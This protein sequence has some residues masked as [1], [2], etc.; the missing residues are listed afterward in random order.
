MRI[1]NSMLIKDMLWNANRNLTGMAKSQNE[2]S[3]GKRIQRP[4]DDPVGITQV[5]KYKADIRETEQYAENISDSLGW[6]EVTESALDDVKEILQRVREL[7]V[8][9]SNGTY[10]P[11]DTTKIKTEI[12]QLTKE[13]IVLGNSTIAGRYIFSGLETDQALFDEDGNYNINISSERNKLKDVLNFEVSVGET[14]EVSTHPIDVFGVISMNNFFEELFAERSAETTEATKAK[15]ELSID[16]NHDYSSSVLDIKLK[17]TAYGDLQY[18]VDE[19]LLTNNISDPLTKSRIIE[20]LKLATIVNS[21]NVNYSGDTTDSAAILAGGTN[22]VSVSPTSDLTTGAY[23]IVVNKYSQES[24]LPIDIDGLF[25][26]NSINATEGDYLIKTAASLT[27]ANGVGS[28]LNVISNIEI[29]PSSTLND[30]AEDFT[31]QINQLDADETDGSIAYQLNLVGSVSGVLE[32]AMTT[33]TSNSGATNIQLGD[34]TFS[35]DPS[36]LWAD[37]TSAGSGA[38]TYGS[39][40]GNTVQLTVSNLVTA[41]QVSTGE[42]AMATNSGVLADGTDGTI[43]FNFTDGGSAS[44]DVVDS[45]GGIVR[46]NSYLTTVS[47]LDMY[48]VSL[49]SDGASAPANGLGDFTFSEADIAATPGIVN[50]IPIGTLANGISID[51]NASAL[52]A[53]S[54]GTHVISVDVADVANVAADNGISTLGKMA[55]IYFDQNDKLVIE[56]KE[57]GDGVS[58]GTKSFLKTNVDLTHDYTAGDVLDLNINGTTFQVDESTL[59]GSVTA[60]T[61]NDIVNAYKTATDGTNLLGDIADIYY[62]PEGKLVI[63]PKNF[64]SNFSIDSS[65]IVSTGIQ[66]ISVGNE[67]SYTLGTD[68]GDSIVSTSSHLTD[69]M[70][71]DAKDVSVLILKVDGEPQNIE[72]D[73]SKLSSVNDLIS[74]IQNQVDDKFGANKVVI[75]GGDG[76]ALDFK[77]LG[78]D[79]GEKHT[80]EVDYQFT[81]ESELVHD[82]KALSAAFE[83]KDDAVI[84]ASLTKLD[85]HLDRVLTA[86]GEVGGKTNRV[87]FISNRVSD[88]KLTFTSLM[89]NVQ[90]VDMAESIMLFKNLEN[91]YRASLSV[92]AKVIQ[93]SLVDF[94]Q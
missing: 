61:Q 39:Y 16:L 2:L 67:P 84:D 37:E 20:A 65:L 18:D 43:T 36:A 44:I 80:L 91:I 60:L 53:A 94:I 85:M 62:N 45:A 92:G 34:V 8:Q 66:E 87:E 63:Q 59:D 14:M 93:P 54:A 69:S 5:L 70:V 31:I 76:A 71:N 79:D 83:V 82:L 81:K 74:E 29:D 52:A 50:D 22:D 9:A 24:V 25:S 41:T 27:A 3:T 86:M 26:F 57:Y 90:D 32:S 19:S 51:L 4:S 68:S 48:D 17:G 55:D 38:A 28:P 56:S 73:F 12:E 64:D 78:T 47:S 23:D 30:G 58:F 42:V 21:M 72:I 89:S 33:V 7:T 40:N 75:T 6:L 88:N 11:E 1:T 49:V 35:L 13:I 46:G 15:T 77:I 10:N